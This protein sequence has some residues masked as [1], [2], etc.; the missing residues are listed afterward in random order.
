MEDSQ[1]VPPQDPEA[2]NPETETE[3]ES[4]TEDGGLMV[5]VTESFATTPDEDENED[6]TESSNN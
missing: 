6:N 2:T 5:Q 1:N 3:T 4:T